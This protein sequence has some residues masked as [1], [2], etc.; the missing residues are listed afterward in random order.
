M[1]RPSVSQR[2]IEA[3]GSIGAWYGPR[4]A[5]ET[6]CHREDAVSNGDGTASLAVDLPAG[7]WVVV[8]AS[9]ECFEGPAGAD[10]FG[11]GRDLAPDWEP[12]GPR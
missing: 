2:E 11:A 12:C 8:S 7:A 6:R 1:S 9:D 3:C 4:P 5:G 10:S